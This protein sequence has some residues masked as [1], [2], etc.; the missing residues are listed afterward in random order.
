MSAAVFAN[1][2]GGA[3]QGQD[4]AGWAQAGWMDLIILMDYQMQALQ[5]RANERQFL[6]VLAN[7][8]QLVTGL[9]LYMRAGGAVSSRPPELVMQQIELVRRMG[10]HGYCL[11]AYSHLSE[12]QLKMLH[13]KINAEP[14][15]PYFR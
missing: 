8:D 7:D 9:S 1:L 11:F 13:D 2:S 15:V 12:P 3:S 14:A 10:I 4:P 5:V 6:V